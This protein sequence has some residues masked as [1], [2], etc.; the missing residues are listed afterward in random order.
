MKSQLHMVTS[1]AEPP[2]VQPLFRAWIYLNDEASNCDIR[3][4]QSLHFFN[5]IQE[6]RHTYEPYPW[7][8]TGC[9]SMKW[10]VPLH[11]KMIVE[12]QQ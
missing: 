6:L 3:N 5:E 4:R 1:A 7:R 12:K 11:C 8:W 10:S 9:Y 2:V